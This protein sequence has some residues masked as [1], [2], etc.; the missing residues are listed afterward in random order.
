LSGKPGKVDDI[1]DII[2]TSDSRPYNMIGL[3]GRLNV[4]LRLR[5]RTLTL[6]ADIQIIDNSGGLVAECINVFKVK[7]KLNST[8]FATVG[9]EIGVVIN[10]ARPIALASSSA[11][12]TIQKVRKGDMRRAVVVRTKKTELRPDGRYVKYV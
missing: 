4:R 8:G 5:S 10:K 9:D 6:H 1:I 12:S 11:A 2:S 3:K 7:T